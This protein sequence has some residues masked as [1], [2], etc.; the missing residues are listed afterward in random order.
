MSYIGSYTPPPEGIWHIPSPFECFPASKVYIVPNIYLFIMKKPHT[1]MYR[2]CFV[3][4]VCMVHV[5][6]Y[7]TMAMCL[8]KR[9]NVPV[10]NFSVMSGRSQLFLGLTSA[11][12]S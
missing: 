9:I 8:E 4:S 10:N 5:S 7:A 2:H 1:R 3:E 11:V 6:T 12:G